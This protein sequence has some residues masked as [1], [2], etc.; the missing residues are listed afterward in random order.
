MNDIPIATTIHYGEHYDFEQNKVVA[1]A[2]LYRRQGYALEINGQ[3][4][5]DIVKTILEGE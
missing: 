1:A 5:T 4:I 2:C 3:D